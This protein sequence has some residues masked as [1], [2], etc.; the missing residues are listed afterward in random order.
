M[1]K[2]PKQLDSYFTYT[3]LIVIAISF[4]LWNSIVLFNLEQDVQSIQNS[5]IKTQ[6]MKNDTEVGDNTQ[7]TKD[8]TILYNEDES[9]DTSNWKTYTNEEYGFS[10]KYPK[11]RYELQ[12]KKK[13][14]KGMK[15][16]GCYFK[17]DFLTCG[18][19]GSSLGLFNIK[20]SENLTMNLTFVVEDYG[21]DKKSWSDRRFVNFKRNIPIG[22]KIGWMFSPGPED[23]GKAYTEESGFPEI[24][25][26]TKIVT[27]ELAEKSEYTEYS[28]FRKKWQCDNVNFTAYFKEYE[29]VNI[30]NALSP[31][32]N[33]ISITCNS[34]E[35]E[36]IQILE[37]MLSSITF[38]ADSKFTE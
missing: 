36:E 22:G 14:T 8:T 23:I 18:F 32:V 20:N 13:L 35:K 33:T 4:L 16:L 34:H 15:D 27:K 38:K 30:N 31:G 1:K 24:T 19:K 2:L 10:V 12:H 7:E 3:L 11:K 37:T 28:A 17:K 21:S 29:F 26:A 9:I 6:K 5:I 25:Y